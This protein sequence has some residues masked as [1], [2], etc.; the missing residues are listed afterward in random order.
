MA[1]PGTNAQHCGT[2]N[3]TIREMTEADLPG[4]DE[5]RR[6]VGW[7]QTSQDWARMLRLSPSGCFVALDGDTIVG[8]VTTTPY[9]STLAW[10]G[11]MLVHPEHRRRG[12]GRQLML[13][14]LESLRQRNVQC[15]KLDATPAGLPLYEQL[16]FV[17]EW[18]LTRHQ[19]T[20]GT[21]IVAGSSTPAPD[22]RVLAES[23]WEGIVKVDA[24]A[25][26]TARE[27]LLRSLAADSVRAVV[28]PAQ[29]LAQGW[30]FL[31]PGANADYLGPIVCLSEEGSASLVA[32]LLTGSRERP[33]FWDVPDL[34][35]AAQA[36]ARAAG[37]EPVR[38]LTRMRRG[39]EK[40]PSNP[41]AQF[42]IADPA[43]G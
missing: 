43:V 35:E 12:I 36:V 39:P 37:F 5:L 40:L 20:P 4:A 6:V 14:A 22:V 41:R 34:N 15:V 32:A 13:R 9:G 30:G 17:R 10:I 42:A 24:A 33:V 27:E 3:S 23:D 8:T 19:L 16:G 21:L 31:R 26:G 7:N 28:W 18:E 29:G 1:N 38:P 11:M 25:F 2:V